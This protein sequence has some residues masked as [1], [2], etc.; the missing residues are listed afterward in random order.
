MG[1]T[2]IMSFC[3]AAF[4]LATAT[5]GLG[6]TSA[7]PKPERSPWLIPKMSGPVTLDGL[8]IEE[9]WQGIASLPLI[10][11]FP[12]FGNP[13]SE[14]TEILLGHDDSFIYIAARLYDREPDKI[15]SPSKK[16][17]Y[18]NTNSDF[19]GV[20]F[21]TFNDK[22]NALGFCTTPAGLRWDGMVVN[23]AM[24]RSINESFVNLSWNTF[25]DVEVARNDQGSFVEMRIPFSSL[26]FQ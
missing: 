6:Q 23:D 25:W 22:E 18:P 24:R 9:A 21:D 15:Q 11:I 1:Q 5:A 20:F 3:A 10:T 17:D 4:L 16:R 14:K 19:V 26:R 8:S 13:P 2:R 12:T 7:F